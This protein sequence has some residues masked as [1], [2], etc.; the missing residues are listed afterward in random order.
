MKKKAPK[1]KEKQEKE[2]KIKNNIPLKTVNIFHK[3]LKK[4][5]PPSKLTVS[6]WADQYRVLSREASSE[7]GKWKTS[8]VP[9]MKEPMDAISDP[10]IE[11][12][13]LMCSAQVAKTELLLNTLGKYIHHEP[14]PMMYLMPQLD[15]AEKFSKTRFAMMVRDTTV[16]SNIIKEAKT[17]DSSNTILHKVFPGGHLVISGSNS[18]ASLSSM[19]IKILLADEV[20]RFADSAGTEGD[21]ISLAEK[22]Q[23][24]FW[25]AKKVYVSTPTDDGKSRIQV[26]YMDGSQESWNLPCPSCGTYQPLSW[27]QIKF[28]DNEYSYVTHECHSCKARHGEVEWKS[29]AGK[30]IAKNENKTHRSFHLN[31][32]VSPWKR[33]EKIV[34]EFLKAKKGGKEMLKVWVNT[35]LGE[36]WIEKGESADHNTLLNRREAYNCEVP[37]GVLVLTAAVDVQ[38]DRL[39]IEVEGWGVGKEN[40]GIEYKVIYG[41]P[42]QKAVWNQLDDYLKRDWKYQD[43]A[44]IGLSCTCVD[45]G[46]CADEVYDF[47]KDKEHRRIFA[48]KGVGGSGHPLVGKPSRANRKRVALFPI[49]VDAGKD[50]IMSRLKIEN[51]EPGYCH[52]PLESDRGYDEAYFKGLTSEQR[53]MSYEKGRPVF[54]WKKKPGHIRNEPLDLKDYNIAALEIF[55]PNLDL[56]AQRPRGNYYKQSAPSNGV[57]A[58]RRRRIISRGVS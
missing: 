2:Y 51:P 57:Q 38:E 12:I 3:V 23:T 48:V 13:T 46:Y 40:W 53:I 47:C 1:K 34:E 4:L 15:L 24:T 27:A 39:E 36:P 30:W 6:E 49:G 44:Q 10:E 31:E 43:G 45:S 52:F 50:I 35:S 21:P 17:K 55:N 32:L 20:D 42:R 28:I 5:A 33:W 7:P 14:S 25:D 16:L 58:Q 26:A 29:G 9:Y 54:K 19:P 11:Q 18:P 22:R 41:N 37:D 8:R 56:L